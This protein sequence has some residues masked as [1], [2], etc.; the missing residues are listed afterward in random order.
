M[1]R[2]FFSAENINSLFKEH[3]KFLI[4]AK[5]SLKMVKEQLALVRDSIRDWSNYLEEYDVYST[6]TQ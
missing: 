6:S 1:D 3:Y 2:G 5:L 4:G